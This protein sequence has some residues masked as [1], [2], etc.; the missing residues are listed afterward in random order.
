MLKRSTGGKNEHLLT[1]ILMFCES[2][3]GAACIFFHFADK[4]SFGVKVKPKLGSSS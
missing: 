2:I 1:E 3:N 4:G